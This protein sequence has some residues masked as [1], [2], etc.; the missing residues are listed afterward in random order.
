[1]DPNDLGV[2]LSV[3]TLMSPPACRGGILT[4]DRFFRWTRSRRLLIGSI[5]RGEVSSFYDPRWTRSMPLMSL[6]QCF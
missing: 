1:V 5:L 3:N 4:S 2:Y 6:G